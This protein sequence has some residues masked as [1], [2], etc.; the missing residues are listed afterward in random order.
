[1]HSQAQ[2]IHAGHSVL[3]LPMHWHC[4]RNL[5][6][7]PAY[8]EYVENYSCFR[9]AGYIQNLHQ[10]L[11][12]RIVSTCCGVVNP[13]SKNSRCP[14]C[15]ALAQALMLSPQTGYTSAHPIYVAN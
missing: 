14:F 7:H 5:D 8:Q 6:M 3:R 15:V 13:S 11:M 1:M 9:E 12:M 2:C 4:L 10:S